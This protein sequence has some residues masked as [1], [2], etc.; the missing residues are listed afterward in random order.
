[1]QFKNIQLASAYTGVQPLDSIA[2]GFMWD[3][4]LPNSEKVFRKVTAFFNII[5]PY[6]SDS[7]D[8][9]RAGGLNTPYLRYRAFSQ[10]SVLLNPSQRTEGFH[11]GAG[12][13]EFILKQGTV[14]RILDFAIRCDTPTNKLTI[15]PYI[16]LDFEE[17]RK[18]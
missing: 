17:V 16:D 10:D 11:R 4:E 6:Y 2:I 7:F 9:Q 15:H 8:T 5:E 12:R 3:C 18:F 1:M 13:Y 14:G